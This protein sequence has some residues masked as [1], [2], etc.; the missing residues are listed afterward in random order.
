MTDVGVGDRNN[1]DF[2]GIQISMEHQIQC[3][4]KAIGMILFK[5]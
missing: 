2:R 1:P 3:R 5:D 4:L